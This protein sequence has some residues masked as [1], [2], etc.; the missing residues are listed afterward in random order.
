MSGVT[1]I[2]AS[3]A[4]AASARGSPE[5]S[6]SFTPEG[7]RTATQRPAP[8][9]PPTAGAGVTAASLPAQE[10]SADASSTL[11]MA[12]TAGATS[13]SESCRPALV[14]GAGACSSSP[15]EATMP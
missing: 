5:K 7:V 4:H 11:S 12:G 13:K 1:R 6:V 10:G 14:P 15:V 9:N 2:D 8:W 3:P